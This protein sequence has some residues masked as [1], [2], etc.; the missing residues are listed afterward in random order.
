MLLIGER[1]STKP[2]GHKMKVNSIELNG[3]SPEPMASYLKA[4]GVLRL[5]SSYSNSAQ[6]IAADSNVRG[7]WKNN[8]FILITKLS[9]DELIEFFV[10]DYA[11][12][13]II[14]PWN[15]RAGFLEP[16]SDN[17][18]RREGAVLMRRMEDSECNRLRALSRTIRL[19]RENDF[20][21]KFKFLRSKSNKLDPSD[22]N[23]KE[24]EKR[25]KKIKSKLLGRIRSV[26]DENHLHYIDA[27]YVLRQSDKME[28][29]LLGSGGN[30]G[31]RDFGVNFASSLERV[32]DFM[33]GSPRSDAA[34]DL[35]VSLL[36]K[37][38]FAGKLG[39][40]GQFNPGLG[41]PNST[42]GY[43]GMN[44][45]NAWDTILAME[46]TFFFAGALTKRLG[47]SGG[48]R[49]SF[50][51]TFEP[52]NAGD[53]GLSSEDPNQPRGEIW[54]PIWHKPATYSEIAAVFAEGRLTIGRR[55]A[56][57]GLDAARSIAQVG[58][59][60]GI[61]EFERYSF[62]QP[63]GKMPYQATPLGRYS[64]PNR[65]RIDLVAD[66]HANGW[67]DRVRRLAQNKMVPARARSTMRR[68]DDALF[69]MTTANRTAEGA[70]NA[71]IAL[72]SLV[73]W[74]VSNRNALTDL[75]PPPPI[76]SDWVRLAYN[77]DRSAEF[78]IAAVLSDIGLPKW[79]EN[80]SNEEEPDSLDTSHSSNSTLSE[81]SNNGAS[82]EKLDNALPMAAHIAPILEEC[83]FF[84]GALSHRR[85]WSGTES[86]PTVVWRSGRLVTNMINV[87]ERR[88]VE[89]S[90]RGFE[91]KP[92][93]SATSARL[94][95]AL[96]FIHGDFNDALCS[97]LFA[98]LIWARPTALRVHNANDGRPEIPFSYATLKPIF[99]P[100]ALLRKLRAIPDGM[101]M[102]IPP[103]ICPRLRV[104][105]SDR[106]GEATDAAVR[107]ALSRARASGMPSPFAA[108]GMSS[109]NML[110]QGGNIGAGI[111]ADR[112]AA[113]LL[114][115]VND[116][117][118][119]TL[120][121]RAYPG[122]LTEDENTKTE[123]VKN[124]N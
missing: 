27:C 79:A 44:P 42:V 96:N 2:E 13:P 5:V 56:R 110:R 85:A 43:E 103:Q 32:F 40:M 62:V 53:G 114:I 38:F 3:C 47:A 92:L 58:V 24:I 26:T 35:N 64:V 30:V 77:Y 106:S 102:P 83:F 6:G 70:R 69:Q 109:S 90:I 50:P 81:T 57:T 82:K 60:R 45:L 10:K 80:I 117:A 55:A 41:G 9:L 23:R 54:V 14:A 74:L 124:A 52:M 31:S 115:P 46:G 98:G 93:E 120:I 122:A 16:D 7:C 4:L 97:A 113:A 119:R 18:S 20:L 63:D 112:I 37:R 105:G 15:G 89:G 73:G 25:I 100:N 76:S 123:D 94:A 48:G 86:P 67:L 99:V 1:L 65:P 12:S 108:T 68:L 91:D 61:N 33:D 71:L 39:T 22:P 111:S 87:L 49:S 84:R 11:P 36:G 75:Q 88:I 66:L 21:I 121:N 59:S 51:F 107:I 95:D 101:T 116:H 118:V 8:R 19:F 72:G 104:G 28:A 29:P 17:T 34:S 78:R